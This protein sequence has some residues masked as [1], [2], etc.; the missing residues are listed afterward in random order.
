MDKDQ[1]KSLGDKAGD[2][3][4]IYLKKADTEVVK[5]GYPPLAYTLISLTKAGFLPKV[6]A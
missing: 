6:T 2:I 5:V 1:I 4:F 3:E